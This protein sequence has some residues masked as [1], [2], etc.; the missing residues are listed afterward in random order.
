MIQIQTQ[1]IRI[2]HQINESTTITIPTIRLLV[3]SSPKI[4]KFAA[5]IF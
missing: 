4:N 3:S 5:K 2:F 1:I